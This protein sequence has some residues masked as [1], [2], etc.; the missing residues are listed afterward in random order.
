MSFRLHFCLLPC[1]YELLYLIGLPA[2][3]E[4]LFSDLKVEY[5]G[6]AVVFP[7]SAAAGRAGVIETYGW[8]L[9]RT[10]RYGLKLLLDH[11]FS[12]L[13]YRERGSSRG[14]A[15]PDRIFVSISKRTQRYILAFVLHFYLVF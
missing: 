12:H 1:L 11:L 10:V 3:D 14:T 5:Q 4:P 15:C 7:R 13:I 6:A 2:G 8:A 9:H